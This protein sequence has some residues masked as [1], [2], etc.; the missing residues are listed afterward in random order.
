MTIHLT[1]MAPTTIVATI[2]V[3]TASAQTPPATA[4]RLAEHFGF[5]GLEVIKIDKN[6]GP[7][8]TADLDADGNQDLIAVN[9]HNSRIDLLYQKPGAKPTDEVPPPSSVNEIPQHWRFRRVEVPVSDRVVAVVAHDFDLDKRMD[10]IYSSD[11]DKIVFLRQSAPGVFE[12]VRKHTVKNLLPSRDALL[13]ADMI[14]DTKPELVAIANGRIQI[15]PF[16]GSDLGTP[17]EVAAGNGNLVAALVEDLDGDGSSDL[18]GLIPD[19]ASPVRVWFGSRRDGIT[20]LGAQNRF[21]MPPLHDADVVRTPGDRGAALAVIEKPSKRLVLLKA[22]RQ[23]ITEGGDQEA[24]LQTWTFTDPSNRKRDTAIADVNGDGLPDLVATNSELNAVSIFAQVPGRG[25][26]S[27]ENSPAYSDLDYVVASDVD[28]NGRAEVFVSSEK[29]GVVGRTAHAAGGLPFPTT[30]PLTGASVPTA[31]GLATVDGRPWAAVVTK[32]GRIY[33]LELIPVGAAEEA[34]VVVALGAL[35]RT[36]D[37]ILA[38]DADQDGL[39]DL[40]LF[41]PDKPMTMLHH[42]PRAQGASGSDAPTFKMLES[43]DMAQFGLA[44]AANAQNTTAADADGDGKPELL[45]ADRNFVRALRFDPKSGWQVVQQVNSARGDA[46]LSSIAL[47]GDRIV[48]GDRENGR[49]VVF[50]HGLGTEPWREI[51]E[52]DVTGFKFNSIAAGKFSGGSDDGLLL[53]GDDGFGVL[54]FSGSRDKLEEFASWRTDDA[55]RVEHELGV[56]DLNDDGLTDVV[57]LDAGKQMLD[58]LGVSQ[59]RNLIPAVS[60]KVFE[61]RHFS[62]GEPREFEPSQALVEDVTG[63]GVND[64]I[65]MCHD[66]IL[67]YPQM[68]KSSSAA[69]ATSP[70]ATP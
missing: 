62:G 43:K 54:R 15:W 17:V 42:E 13:V 31:L 18:M 8:A 66:R 61:S 56:G 35:S 50:G 34:K 25:F 45:V 6:G 64:L 11:K 37:T 3:A 39:V 41:T 1:R 55:G 12:S 21:E 4:D 49:I 14:G 10:L 23:Q 19:D 5:D 63:D 32:D 22:A 48:A 40:L 16:T 38:L 69:G 46:K 29:E 52:F 51:D 70:P 47:Q 30:L 68:T 67:V 24:S 60:F 26:V 58:I 9:N 44:Q 65:L 36:P 27:S 57:A 59:G 28:G 20:A 53:V 7:I 2:F 33:S